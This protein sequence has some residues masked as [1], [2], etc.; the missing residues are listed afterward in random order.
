VGVLHLDLKPDNVLIVG[1]IPKL[2]DFGI[3]DLLI[4]GQ[5]GCRPS[6]NEVGGMLVWSAP[7]MMVV[8]TKCDP[9]E[10]EIDEKLGI[11]AFACLVDC[12]QWYSKRRSDNYFYFLRSAVPVIVRTPVECL[13]RLH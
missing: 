2:A 8:H 4:P 11:W 5:G 7:E 1:D 3:A 6:R 10:A 13:L 12:L 9:G